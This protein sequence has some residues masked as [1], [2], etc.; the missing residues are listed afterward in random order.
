MTKDKSIAESE[1]K[2]KHNSCVGYHCRDCNLEPDCTGM[3]FCWNQIK[4]IYKELK[5]SK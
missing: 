3:P 1:L 5:D 2:W 4:Y